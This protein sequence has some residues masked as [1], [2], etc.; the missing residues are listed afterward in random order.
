MRNP[1]TSSGLPR[2]ESR[3]NWSEDLRRRLGALTFSPEREAEIIEELSQHLDDRVRE[4]SAGGAPEQEARRRALAELSD[5]DLLSPHF[6]RLRQARAADPVQPGVP[7]ARLGRDLWQDVRYA[8]RTARKQPTFTAAAVLTLALGIG[9]NTAIFSLVNATLLER[10]PVRAP[11]ELVYVFNGG[12]G[13]VFSYPGYVAL[14]DGNRVFD[15]CLA[16][17]GIIA[18]LNADAVTDTVSGLIVTGNFFELLGVSAAR[19]RL[20]TPADDVTVGGHPV[21]V[22]SHQLWQTRLGARPDIVGHEVMLNGHRFTIV[23][24]TPPAFKGPEVGASRHLYVP[25]M[26]QAVMRPPRARYSGEMNPDLLK[27]P[28]NSW[29]ALMGRLKPGVTPTQAEQELGA[30]ATH[31]VRTLD[32]SAPPRRIPVIPANDGDPAQRDRMRSVAMLLGCVVGVVLLIACVNVANLLLSRTA[33][34]RRELAVRLA[35]GA[36]RWRIV[37]QLVTE[38]VLLA[39]GGG[40]VG[41][42]LAWLLVQSFGAWPPP[43]GALPIAIDFAI[44]WRVL[45]FAFVLSLVTGFAFGLLPALRASRPDLLPALKDDS[46]VPDERSRRLGLKKALVV[47][48]VALSIGLLVVAGLFVRSLGAARAIDPGIDADR[49]VNVP[50]SVNLLRYTRAQGRQFYQQVIDRSQALPGVESAAVARVAVLTG[51]A[52]TSSL[53]IEGRTASRDRFTSEGGGTVADDPNSINVNVVSPGFL[54]TLGIGLVRGRD[55]GMGD[56]EKA[57]PVAIVTEAAARRHF[58]DTDPIGKRISIAGPEGPWLQIV[59]IVR[60]SKYADISESPLPVVYLPLAQNHETGVTLYV[61]ATVPPAS[62]VGA[63]RR[64][65]QTLEPNLPIGD[66]R[67]MSETIGVALYAPR[68]GAVLLS[69]FGGLAL[70][71]AAVG[72]Y[73]VLSFSIA[74]RTRE[75]GIRVAL[76]ADAGKVFGLV[77]REGMTLVTIGT[78]VGLAAAAASA[79][80]LGSFLYTIGPRDPVAFATAPIVLAAV[81]LLACLVPAYRAMRVSPVVALRQS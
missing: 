8:L 23:G 58:P 2:A 21:A 20:L 12:V 66:I 60:D 70:L 3:G 79:T 7:S 29:L 18:S 77:L 31:Y 47:T 56:G 57:P 24:V 69:A 35:I 65:V 51:A 75:M 63:L 28:G 6:A 25:M 64:E 78:V 55:F 61:R 38:S 13:G 52:R 44:D 67:T 49:L 26:M 36:S 50:L 48:E 32:P 39:I 81:A 22:V 27:T 14:R 1:S 4:L 80:W 54:R 37:R 19:G 62:L 5:H 41:V 30:L 71:L 15:G 40:I 59:G 72:V 42:A 17:G 43:S 10:L 9:G 53:L 68:M 34:R 45:F 46:F 74:Q 33:S 76:G 16:A 73:G 11:H